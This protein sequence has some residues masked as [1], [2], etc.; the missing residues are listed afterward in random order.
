ME[1]ILVEKVNLTNPFEVEEIVKFL[2]KF[3]L[4]FESGIDYSIA[5]RKGGVI[6]GTCSKEKN[7]LKCFAVDQSAQG[8]GLTNLMIKKLQDKLFNEGKYHSFIFTKKNI[9]IP[10]VPW[11][12]K[13]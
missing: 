9:L 7:V 6:I 3:D 12:I 13:R 5:A 1:G 2:E 8:E 11:G 10:S 4:K